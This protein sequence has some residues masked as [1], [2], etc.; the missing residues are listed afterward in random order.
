MVF[1]PTAKSTIGAEKVTLGRNEKGHC[2][3]GRKYKHCHEEIDRA[4]RNKKDGAPQAVY[5]RNCRLTS[6]QHHNDGVYR[7][8]AE[9]LEAVS[10]GAARYGWT[11]VRFRTTLGCPIG[12]IQFAIRGA[13]R[14]VA[15]DTSRRRLRRSA[16]AN[17]YA[18]MPG[19]RMPPAS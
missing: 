5:A 8:L 17:A 16:R 7:W 15:F 9:Q 2:G 12:K 19:Y 11:W 1:P 3:S 6:Q 18:I 10:A 14:T 4:P 13:F